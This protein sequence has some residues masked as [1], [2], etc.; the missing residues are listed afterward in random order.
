MK[1][2]TFKQ[3]L[4]KNI[5]ISIGVALV[6]LIISGVIAMNCAIYAVK[7]NY[8]HMQKQ[9]AERVQG[10]YFGTANKDPNL[11]EEE[12]LNYV[13]EIMRSD[14]S[15]VHEKVP[16]DN[17][18]FSYMAIY[19]LEDK[20]LIAETHAE[21]WIEMGHKESSYTQKIWCHTSTLDK[22]KEY[23]EVYSHAVIRDYYLS[24]NIAYLG[25]VDFYNYVDGEPVETVDFRPSDY[26][27][28]EYVEIDD[29]ENYY[30]TGLNYYEQLKDDRKMIEIQ[31]YIEDTDW[32]TRGFEYEV[33]GFN[34]FIVGDSNFYLPDG[35]RYVL[36]SSANVDLFYSYGEWIIGYLVL[37]FVISISV[38]ILISYVKYIKLKSIYEMDAYRRTLTDSMAHDL[39]SPLM[40]V[41]GYAENLKENVN[42]DKKDYYA[43]A[44]IDNAQYMNSIIDNVLKL[45]QL[46]SNK[47]EIN[48][49]EIDLRALINEC[50]RKYEDAFEEKNL[51]VDIKGDMDV[52]GDEGL[53]LQAFDNLISNA[54]K[55]SDEDSSIEICI[56]DDKKRIVMVNSCK[57]PLSVPIEELCQPFIKGDNARSNKQG[58]G[59]GLSISNTI[60]KMHGFKQ[61]IMCKNEEFVV[62]IVLSKK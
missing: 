17:I 50:L 14:V 59:I 30:F 10:R 58:T 7:K 36:F 42:T 53:L 34:I 4:F 18:L 9:Y 54:T 32:E 39:K 60:F 21:S 22:I 48:K 2:K 43:T 26:S 31:N 8:I 55:Y 52:R 45:S 20:A 27:S 47:I 41:S 38:S 51:I 24:G 40:A 11:T 29:S 49:T 25:K 56:E 12:V 23:S 28:Y 37:I 62:E 15:I 19:R 16:V 33:N 13:Y 5:A 3:I 44:I 61:N 1:R 35:S 46:E 57:T 6:L